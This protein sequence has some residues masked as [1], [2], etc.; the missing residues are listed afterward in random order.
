MILHPYQQQGCEML[1]EAFAQDKKALVFCLPTGGGKT[2]CFSDLTKKCLLAGW[3]VLIICNRKELIQQ[4]KEKLNNF[5]LYPTLI[6]PGY[7]DHEARLYLA[8]VDTLRNRILPTVDL[9]II[10]EAHLKS[11]D[12]IALTYK[13]RGTLIIGATATPIRSGKAKLPS[14]PEYAGNMCDIYDEIIEPI[15]I[16]DLIEN[17][18]LTPAIYHGPK[19]DVG[20]MKAKKTSYGM[21]YDEK[22]MFQM[23]NKPKL[24]DGLIDNYLRFANGEKALVFN[25]NV[26]HSIKMSEAF[27]V[28]G[29]KSM[30]VDGKTPLAERK[31]IFDRFK[32]GEIQVLNNCAI[33]TTGYDEPSI[34]CIIV[35]RITMSLSLWL[36]MVGR[37]ARKYP[38]KDFFKVIDQGGNIWKHGAWHSDRVWSLDPNKKPEGAAPIKMCESCEAI[39]SLSARV[40]PYCQHLHLIA[41]KEKDESLLN[42]EFDVLDLDQVPKHLKKELYKMSVAELEEYRE[43]KKYKPDWVCNQIYSRGDEAL[44]EYG[45]L[46]GYTDKWVYRHVC[47]AR[48]KRILAKNQLWELLLDNP[49]FAEDE[50]KS[51]TYKR[52]GTSHRKEDIDILLPK[53]FEELNKVKYGT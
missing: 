29:I 23:F 19:V 24:Y 27:N 5:G 41:E 3:K 33:A 37:G 39:I 45:I 35:N 32:R 11:F 7:K 22:Q 25:V 18:F 12:E 40:C 20:D 50:I 43:L 26:E 49:S 52:L 31:K 2:V 44:K 8:S 47:I 10:D 9:V 28:R 4:A 53:I 36:Q 46:K 51:Y 1:S 16:G 42:A 14:F 21:D 30:H 6:I 48:D 17:D 13:N 34:A 15:R 38:G